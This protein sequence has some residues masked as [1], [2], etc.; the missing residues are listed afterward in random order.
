MTLEKW[1][2]ANNISL[3][4]FEVMSGVPYQRIS[5]HIRLN[6]PLSEKHVVMILK[7][8]NYKVSPVTLRPS[9]KPIFEL[10]SI[11]RRALVRRMSS[12]AFALAIIFGL[13]TIVIFKGPTEFSD[14]VLLES[15]H[16]YEEA[17][18]AAKDGD[19]D[20][21][22]SHLEAIEKKSPAWYES[23]EFHWQVKTELN[24]YAQTKSK[25]MQE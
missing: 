7:A 1:L 8:T 21:A 20:L 15:Q 12:F 5:E 2:E 3:T 9:L 22:L 10:T 13:F 6:K 4:D 19:F 25:T 16:H 11:K 23:R 18:K 17:Q 14:P 24:K